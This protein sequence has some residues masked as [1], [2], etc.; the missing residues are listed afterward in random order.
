MHMA[1]VLTN[2]ADM[3]TQTPAG[4][5]P[6]PYG[7]PRLR[8]WDGSQWT[9]AT[10][11]HE[12][13]QAERPPAQPDTGPGWSAMPANPTARYGTPGHA[14][15]AYGQP[16]PSE[17]QW[18]E[19]GR[20]APPKQRDPLPWVFGGVGALVVLAL[21]AAAA[22]FF[23]NRATT[24][25]ASSTRQSPGDTYVPPEQQPPFQEPPFGQPPGRG[26]FPRTTGDRITDP[27]SG[28]SFK[29]PDG[30]TVPSYDE[31]NSGDPAQQAWTAAVQTI[32]QHAY[33]GRD[34]WVGGVYSGVL[35]PAYPYT[36]AK[37]M[38]DTAKA[39]YVDFSTKYYTL[40]HESRIV[41][42]KAMKIGDRDAWLLQFELDF[43]KISEENGYSWKKE[44]G[45]IVLM[46]RGEG[47]RP[48]ILYVTVPDN[49]GGDVVGKVLGSLQPA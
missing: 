29:A 21:I 11:A 45:A 42:D 19:L 47:R 6:D 43:S 36:G 9:D 5:Y 27:G 24:P 8:W 44:N 3:T 12:Q 20:P 25:A 13:G 4:W 38:S 1:T 14:Q 31:V 37:S 34:H 32:A 40:A 39:V 41:A 26:T 16:A 49:L 30:W 35:N 2:L 46:D 15:S 23:V 17:P 10:H 18:G 7:E 48:A 33:D 28:L 22:I